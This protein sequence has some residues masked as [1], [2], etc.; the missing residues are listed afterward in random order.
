M[1]KK[2]TQDSDGEFRCTIRPKIRITREELACIKYR[3]EMSLSEY[4]EH[5]IWSEYNR[6]RY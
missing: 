1:Q 6:L 2:F 4:I 5:K 3:K